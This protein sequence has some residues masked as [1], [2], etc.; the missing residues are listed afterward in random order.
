MTY[1]LFG[2][3]MW[4]F[5]IFIGS[6][7]RGPNWDIYWPW[8]SWLIHKPPPPHTWSLPFGVGTGC[9]RQFISSSEWF[10]RFCLSRSL[11]G[12]SRFATGCSVILGAAH[13]S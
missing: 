2:V 3:G 9:R 1:F 13:R 12:K 6:F 8:E 7:L 11:S 4:F 5:L 10:C